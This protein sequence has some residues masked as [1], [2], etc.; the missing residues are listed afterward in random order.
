MKLAKLDSNLIGQKL[1]TI[2]KTQD[3][4]KLINS[5]NKISQK[6]L[7]RLLNYGMNCLYIEDENT[8]L[9]L[10][11][12]ISEDVR[13][14]IIKK[15]NTIYE[16]ISKKNT[17]DEYELNHIVRNHILMNINNKPISLP[18][19][20][21]LK[22][23]DLAHHSLNVCLLCIMTANQYGLPMDRVEILA[24]AALLHDIG[25]ILKSNDNSMSHGQMAYNFLRHKTDSVILCNA[26]RFHHE[27]LD[28]SGP[29]KLS[30]N[31]QGDLIKIL[32]LCNYYENLLNDKNLVQYECFEKIQALANTKFDGKVF[33]AFKKS[34]H[35]YPIGLPVKLNTGEEGIVARQNNSFPLRP[36][37]RTDKAEYNLINNLSLF[38]S[39]VGL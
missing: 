6:V 10:E 21:T 26:I 32:S 27:T 23:Q 30:P 2:I 1:G 31:H 12:S 22:G 5:G 25:K 19:G 38:I 20:R 4:Q 35:I 13:V 14:E 15:L 39:E 8:D 3:G 9:E 16:N 11:E 18:I 24:K 37:V 33:E 29:E 28:E 7:E 34:I 17:F 36:I